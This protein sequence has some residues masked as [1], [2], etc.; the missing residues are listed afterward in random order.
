VSSPTAGSSA[1]SG[2]L[3]KTWG[4]PVLDSQRQN[5]NSPKPLSGKGDHR[6]E[7]ESYMTHEQFRILK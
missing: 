3:A 6:V 7:E 5:R 4:T 2:P 1:P